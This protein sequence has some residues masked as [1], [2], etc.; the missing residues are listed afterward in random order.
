MKFKNPLAKHIDNDD[1][2]TDVEKAMAM[3][4][5][6]L[7]DNRMPFKLSHIPG[8]SAFAQQYNAK[9]DEFLSVSKA[10]Q[11]N[12]DP[13]TLEKTGGIDRAL[14]NIGP[15]MLGESSTYRT[16]TADQLAKDFV[17]ALEQGGYEMNDEAVSYTH[18]TLPTIYSV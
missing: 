16:E 9:L 1:F 3:R 2:E 7:G 11:L 18:L 6:K 10:I 14:S 13:T 15:T 8:N 4:D 12:Y 5:V 17:S